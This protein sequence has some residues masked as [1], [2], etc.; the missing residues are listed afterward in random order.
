MTENYVF[1]LWHWT[2]IMLVII[3]VVKDLYEFIK[4]IHIGKHKWRIFCEGCILVISINMLIYFT[5]NPII[6]YI[7]SIAALGR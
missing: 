4:S 5:L 2:V 7:D 1:S 6:K 3:S